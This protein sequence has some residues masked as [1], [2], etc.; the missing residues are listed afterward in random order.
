[1]K[2]L[3]LILALSFSL[4]TQDSRLNVKY[5]RIED[6]TNV[7]TKQIYLKKSGLTMVAYFNH[8]GKTLNQK[9]DAVGLVF[10]ASGRDWKFLHDEDSRLFIL[11]DS[12]RFSPKGPNRKSDVL[13]DGTTDER[14]TFLL[15]MDDLSKIVSASKVEV[16]LGQNTFT[17]GNDT[18]ERLRQLRDAAKV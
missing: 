16:K 3:I 2:P 17:L 8:Q 1:M 12:E 4:F 11:A 10:Y 7:S 6:R 14:L 13:R 9:I 5:D 18:I 15:T